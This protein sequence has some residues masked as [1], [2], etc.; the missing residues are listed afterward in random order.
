MFGFSNPTVDMNSLKDM[1]ANH[2]G[3]LK[4]QVDSCRSGQLVALNLNLPRQCEPNTAEIC[5]STYN[6]AYAVMLDR[7]VY[8]YGTDWY[9]RELCNKRIITFYNWQQLEDF[10]RLLPYDY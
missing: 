10:F 7:P 8:Y 9:L 1:T 5:F 2:S 3:F 4:A 6:G